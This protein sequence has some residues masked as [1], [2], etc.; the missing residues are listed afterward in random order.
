MLPKRK[1]LLDAISSRRE[2]I[3]ANNKQIVQI[4]A[5]IEQLKDKQ[6]KGL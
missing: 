6:T 5:K 4:R 1:N 3:K 2:R